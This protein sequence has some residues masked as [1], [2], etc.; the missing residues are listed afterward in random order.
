MRTIRIFLSSPGDCHAER[1]ATHAVAERL[2]AD[3]VVA[4]FV[5]IQVVAWD[6]GAG[7][8]LDA[9]ASPQVS[10]NQRLPAPED[11][12]VFVGIF[13]CRFGTPLPTH[14][15]VR[16]DG[17]PFQS[18][19]EY[20]F[21]RAWK[22]R[23]RGAAAPDVLMYRLDADGTQA[24]TGGTQLD[25]L[26]AFFDG[27]PF[28]EDDRWTGSL[29]RFPDTAGFEAL[30][31][32]HLRV[33][34]SQGHPGSTP[35][36]R[37][38]LERIAHRMTQDA[39]PRYTRQ[40]HVDSAVAG[41]F[42]WLLARPSAVDA[43]DGRLRDIW[44][45]LDAPE[46]AAFKADMQ[47]IAATLR[48]D[49]RWESAPDL[50]SIGHVLEQLAS[51][52]WQLEDAADSGAS[53]SGD[54]GYRRHALRKVASGA[55]SV[56]AL[57]KE[58]AAF[59]QQRVLL[60]SGPAG[61]G[62]THTLVHEMCRVL[63]AGAVAIGVLGQTLPDSGD[64]R[65]AL[66]RS[67]GYAGSFD[68]FLDV[69][70]NAAAQKRQR[71]LIVI[72]AL[73]ETPNRS[74]WKNELN[75]ILHDILQRPHLTV[76]FSVRSDYL[77]QVLPEVGHGGPP[78]WVEHKHE[79]FGGIESDALLS[80]CAHY[81]VAAPVAPPVGELGNPL[82]VQLLVK[83]LQ[84]RTAPSHWLPSWLDVWAAWIN[85]LEGEARER[86]PFDPSR[87]QPIRRSLKKLADAMVASGTFR[88]TRREADELARTVAG[89][90]GVIGFLCSAGALI[91]RIDDDDDII[92]FGFERLCDTF[93]AD[94]LLERLFT[95]LPTASERCEALRV[96]LA[97]GGEL[98]ALTDPSR[99]EDPLA[100]RRAGLLEALCL[101][102]PSLT[103]VE[104]PQ[105]IPPEV[106]DSHGWIL[107][108]H[109]LRQ[110]FTDSMRWRCRAEE[111]AGDRDSLWRT[112][113]RRGARMSHSDQ[114]DE[115]IRLGLIPGHPFAVEHVLH[116]M[117]LR[118]ASP[119]ARD[120]I[121]SIDLVT[122]WHD[123]SSNLSVLV[124]W[125]GEAGLA[126]LRPDIA[127]PASRL[128][129]WV[130]A[131]SQQSLREA[132]TRGL[133]RMLV[134][135]PEVLPVVLADFLMVNDDYVL[136]SVLTATLGVVIGSGHADACK[137]ASQRVYDAIFVP[138][139]PRCHLT[140]RHYARRIVESA[141]ER[142]WVDGLDMARVRPPYK[143][144]L[145]LTEVP[146]ETDLRALDVS[147][148]FHNIISS[149]LGRD[150]YWYV[151]GGTSGAKPFSSRPLPHSSEPVRAYGDD[152][153]DD[154]GGRGRSDIFN[155]PLAARFVVWNCHRL[156][157]TA[158]RFDTFDTG[159]EVGG[160]G[161][162]AGP[163]RTERIGKKY[164]WISWQTMLAFLADN[165]EMT[166]ERLGVPRT[167]DAP[168]Q[169][170]YIEMLDPSRWL[171]VAQKPVATVDS[172]AL[173]Q[174][175]SLPRWPMGNDEDLL[176][177]G[178]SSAFDLPA[179]DVLSHVPRLPSGWGE[180]P[181][182]CVAAEHVWA[183]PPCPGVWGLNEERNADIWWQLI[184]ALIETD[185]LP[186]LLES[187]RQQP[188]QDRLRQ[189]GRIDLEGDWDV[190]LAEWPQLRDSFDAGLRRGGRSHDAWL[191]V[192]WMH[193]TGQCGHPD[194]KDQEGP[195][196]LPWPR[197][198]REWN[199]TLD[200]ERGVVSQAG[201]VV[202]GLAGWLMGEDALFARRS[203]L[204]ALLSK[205]GM[206]LVWWLRG[207]RRAHVEEFGSGPEARARVWIDSHGVAYL[208]RDGRV[209]VAWL[210]RDTRDP[211]S[212]RRQRSDPE[213]PTPATTIT[214]PR[215]G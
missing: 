194:R 65:G 77:L 175:A 166:P 156:G 110:A 97:P 59:A 9:L 1:A 108:D 129:A 173:W 208:G 53:S 134:A 20:E 119:G 76:A 3:P 42:D 28:K 190:P 174:V 83:S 186:T 61:Q 145:P 122:L 125:A 39:G 49:P 131:T 141:L 207:E 155:I 101:A 31:E 159:S 171:H 63:E 34:L 56:L 183:A 36:L 73:N 69:L 124:R 91:D 126:G 139:A 66:L 99:F 17:S 86:I 51:K 95:G 54:G 148:G 4:S 127:L 14:E 94:R 90:D 107:P 195:V 121:W 25:L 93:F 111:F 23:R 55:Q 105:L 62:K 153:L 203:A 114:L 112:Y 11:C 38:W 182:I 162:M 152:A 60:L 188:V 113:R 87:P 184:P 135:C 136:E 204:M 12:D 189:L 68:G 215:L 200:L 169:I 154:A 128:L 10:V 71:A 40:M 80:Y 48:R 177:W 19:S 26:N 210:A 120:A 78:P 201:N 70:E 205:F 115:L 27:P 96:A 147:S 98:A 179:A 47:H 116:P 170:S 167:Y 106:P 160:Y 130:C 21:D 89:I 137:A 6:W 199:L 8:P 64:L 37:T 32:G 158:E 67:W 7:V 193:M 43:L 181:W 103:G 149:A 74:R 16:E 2:N 41:V 46:L 57:L 197:L 214:P 146:S 191:P 157:W 118:K 163:G 209:Q 202:F 142:G 72:D 15:F 45:N 81:G 140:I 187:L 44:K 138:D 33:V 85:R 164:Q 178:A 161:R 212:R 123:D 92:E 196:I 132:A 151:M 211:V 144:S 143:S 82:F 213:T 133:T 100:D 176:R 206:T 109:Q 168:H 172:E 104:L 50:D 192:P 24:C 117:L 22:A 29:N 185:Q 18:G 79:G 52:A 84:G 88:L 102:V 5:R 180:G 13:R 165:Y 30:L 198:F 58:R 150:F 75:G 35:P